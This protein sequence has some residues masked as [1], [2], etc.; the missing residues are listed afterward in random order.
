MNFVTA[1]QSQPRICVVGNS[2]FTQVI[3]SLV[4]EFK[5]VAQITVI[6]NV[7][8]DAVRA[9]R[10]LIDA[11]QVDF[12]VSAGANAFYLKDTLSVPV[13]GLRVS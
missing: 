10:E 7:F 2:K 6:D 8:N 4:D 11:Q 12:F 13:L 5:S 9:A 1:R 3:H